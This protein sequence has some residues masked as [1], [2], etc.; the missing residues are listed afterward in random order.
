MGNTF[1]INKAQ[2][3]FLKDAMYNKFIKIFDRYDFITLKK[4]QNIIGREDFETVH[5]WFTVSYD[6]TLEDLDKLRPMLKYLYNIESNSLSDEITINAILDD[7][8]YRYT[9]DM[10]LLKA[11]VYFEELGNIDEWSL[12]DFL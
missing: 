6:R 4:F 12:N 3:A 8:K 1:N 2:R 11:K 9:S 5:R 10:V 7:V